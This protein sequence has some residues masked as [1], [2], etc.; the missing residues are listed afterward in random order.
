MVVLLAAEPGPALAERRAVGRDA[1]DRDHP[2]TVLV[3][4]PLEPGPSGPQLVVVEL[5]GPDALTRARGS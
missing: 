3:H 1:G 5:V 4:E 2:W